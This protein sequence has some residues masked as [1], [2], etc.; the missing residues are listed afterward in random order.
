[1]SVDFASIDILAFSGSQVPAGINIPNYDEIR[2]TEGFK[3][4][5]LGNVGFAS[6]KKK[7]K[8]AF[9]SQEDYILLDKLNDAAFDVQV[10]LH[11]L[12]G[13]GSGKLFSV[14]KDG[15]ANYDVKTVVNPLNNQTVDPK[16]VY[17]VENVSN[18]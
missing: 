12:L 3:N 7:N 8:T 17:Q 4:V 11:E 2:Q 15:K 5:N 10:G 6:G 18:L 1:M 14:D 9:A 13:H 16:T